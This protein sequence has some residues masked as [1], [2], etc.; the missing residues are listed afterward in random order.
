VS[1]Y[2]IFLGLVSLL[3]AATLRSPQQA[4]IPE[5]ASVSA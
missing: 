3:S 5:P 4:R 2:V 1:A